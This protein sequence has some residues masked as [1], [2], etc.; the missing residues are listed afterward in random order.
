[1][2][3]SGRKF[4]PEILFTNFEKILISANRLGIIQRRGENYE[5]D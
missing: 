1:M 4:D 3:S 2:V 5:A